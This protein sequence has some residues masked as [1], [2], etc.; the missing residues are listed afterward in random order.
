MDTQQNVL[1]ANKQQS[2]ATH[3]VSNLNGRKNWLCLLIWKL[4]RASSPAYI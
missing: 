4:D 2:M 1:L 3:S